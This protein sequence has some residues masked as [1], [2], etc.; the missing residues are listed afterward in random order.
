MT[1]ENLEQFSWLLGDEAAP[2]AALQDARRYE[3]HVSR[4]D[5]DGC[6]ACLCA[7]SGP[8][9]HCHAG[10]TLWAVLQPWLVAAALAVGE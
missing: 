8:S 7:Y 1:N 2:D 5:S 9:P 10:K 3:K 4:R 6:W